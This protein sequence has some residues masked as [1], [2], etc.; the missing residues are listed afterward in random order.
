MTSWTT[1]LASANVPAKLLADLRSS[2]D[3]FGS[4]EVLER[5]MPALSTGELEFRVHHTQLLVPA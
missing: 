4:G 5:R 2:F 1:R 3:E